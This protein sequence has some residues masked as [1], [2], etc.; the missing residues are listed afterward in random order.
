MENKRSSFAE[1]LLFVGGILIIGYLLF[2]Y[3]ISV[4]LP[5]VIAYFIS[6]AIFPLS[7]TVS[8]KLKLPPRL[9][10]ATFVILLVAITMGIIYL[11][12]T[13][14]VSEATSLIARFESDG[15]IFEGITRV[16]ERIRSF[17]S[18]FTLLNR[19]EEAFGVENIGARLFS[20]L[21]ESIYAM[22]AKIPQAV[23]SLVGKT[24]QI[25]IGV[26]VAIMASY[27]FVGERERISE[28]LR[29]LLPSAASRYAVSG[30]R[31]LK[32]YARAY[33]YLMLITF[34]ETFL[35]L[36]F[37]GVRYS[38]LIA[39]AI[40]V[41]D[42]LP[43]LGA[44]TVLIPWSLISFFMGDGHLALGLIILYGI[45]TVIRQLCEPKI[46]G[47][48][49]G[50]HPLAS[51]FSVYAGFRLFGILGMI[52]GPA[53]ALMIKEFIGSGAEPELKGQ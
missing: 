33:L 29:Q 14:L 39:L 19:L 22:I 53:A 15:A 37:L 46:I 5:F 40:A 18:Q 43:V 13:R 47:D 21:A 45:M 25:F 30:A 52:L 20:A 41:V 12:V 49:L 27:Y 8:K 16:G 48:S 28:Y 23:G 51:L 32:R 50:L 38:F 11:A 24:P 9:V 6:C 31:A 42:I 1:R 3:A 35:G 44:G 10:G 7:R 2:K 4:F 17:F 26:F 34:G 36:A